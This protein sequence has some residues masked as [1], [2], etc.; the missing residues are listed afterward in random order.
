MGASP[1]PL[2]PTT[3]PRRPTRRSLLL[4]LAGGILVAC[5]LGVPLYLTAG[6]DLRYYGALSSHGVTTQA[7]VT[8]TDS[9]NHNGVCYAFVVG[10]RR[11][12]SC[13]TSDDYETSQLK[14]GQLIHIVYDT[15]NPNV[16]CTCHD[17]TA[18]LSSERNFALF[19][20][21]VIL[22]AAVVGGVMVESKARDRLVI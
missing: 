18:R 6:H 17:P 14:R 5:L 1:T 19:V 10:T 8:S 13:G 7:A 12:Q 20:G 9:Q 15:K 3:P 2:M 11:H 4:G 16:S 21:S 22:V